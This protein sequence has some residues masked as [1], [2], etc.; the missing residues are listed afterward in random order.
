[1][2]V[3]MLLLSLAALLLFPAFAGAQFVVFNDE[4]QFLNAVEGE[5][6]IEFEEVADDDSLTISDQ[7]GAFTRESVAF[8]VTDN[9]GNPGFGQVIGR[10]F[11]ESIGF[12]PYNLGSGDFFSAVSEFPVVIGMNF[13]DVDP[14]GIGFRVDDERES[15]AMSVVLRTTL[16]NQIETHNF[17]VDTTAGFAFFGFASTNGA[18]VLDVTVSG[19]I[20]NRSPSINIDRVTF[21]PISTV[22]GPGA[23]PIFGAGLL[24]LGFRLRRRRA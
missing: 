3:F 17:A 19:D 13:E 5:T 22:P 10:D 15:D 7:D 11:H 6:I 12:P 16:N 14:A 24:A 23:L 2:R 1:M 4:G 20:D 21:A 8:Q 18:T 9:R